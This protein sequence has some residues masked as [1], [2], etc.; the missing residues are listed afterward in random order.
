ME[1]GGRGHQDDVCHLQP[2]QQAHTTMPHDVD[3]DD[4]DDHNDDM[5]VI[6]MMMMMVMMM[7]VMMM[8]MIMMVMC[9]I[10]NLGNRHT[11]HYLNMMMLMMMIG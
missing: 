9:A 4:D 10:F 11:P 6:M 3:D 5:V 2:R 1:R 7:M 8:M